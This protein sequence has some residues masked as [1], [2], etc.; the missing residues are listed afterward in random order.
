MKQNLVAHYQILMIIWVSLLFS[1]LLFLIVAFV[2]KPELFRFDF[3]Q[4]PL[5]P[6][7]LVIL[8]LAL[9]A[10]ACVAASFILKRRLYERAVEQQDPGQVQSGLITALALCE[11]SSLIGLFLAFAFDYQYF[12]LWFALGVLGMLFH[13]PSQNDLLA[14]GYRQKPGR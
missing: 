9:I 2:A 8:G 6:S 1:Q 11:G 12:F 13:F 7:S 4:G 10:L 5:E 14:A 3:S